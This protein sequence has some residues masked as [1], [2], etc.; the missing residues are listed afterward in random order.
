MACLWP[1]WNKYSFCRRDQ[2]SDVL[3]LLADRW[4]ACT[5]DRHTMRH[6]KEAFY[7]EVES[8]STAGV[9]ILCATHCVF[10]VLVALVN[11]M[12]AQFN[13]MQVKKHVQQERQESRHM[14]NLSGTDNK[15]AVH[16]NCF[17]SSACSED[18]ACK[19]FSLV[20]GSN[21]AQY[22]HLTL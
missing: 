5:R 6:T 18:F 3:H 1:I 8:C 17:P 14:E 7:P 13:C 9:N 2:I 19:A 11:F 4:S 12:S 21:R 22:V 10:E 20:S 15:V 16:Q